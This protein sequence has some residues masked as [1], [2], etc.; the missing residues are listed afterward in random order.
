[1]RIAF[2][3]LATSHPF[4]DAR[5]L[6]R[7][8]ELSVWEED[9][10]RLARF[11]A[12]H[13]HARVARDLDDLLAPGADGIVLTVQ[14]P[15]VADVLEPVLTL[16]APCFVNK[17]AAAT[18]A[19]LER[20]DALVSPHS[21]KV[22]TSSVLRF[23]PAFAGY[24]IGSQVMSVRATVRHD[25]GLW[26][27]GYNPWQ[28][29]PAEGGG[30]LVTMGIHGVELLVALLGPHVR[31]AGAAG[32]LRRHKGL[33]SEDTGVMAL[34]WESGVTGVVEILGATDVESYTVSVHT[35]EDT[36]QIVIESGADVLKGLG[37]EGTIDAFLSMVHGAPSPV[38]WGETRA[39]LNILISARESATRPL[40]EVE[41]M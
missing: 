36:E 15:R 4:T 24:S 9:A 17:P 37:Y 2:A 10:E 40:M 32:S 29:D 13:P 16:G 38:P 41:R 6:A 11:T 33:R 21:E 28:D 30:T 25:V 18:R 22:L 35:A 14:T 23:A 12:E 39:I 1:M 27:T 26:A 20:L 31:L 19:Q 7:H 8:A 3:G 34:I 5:T